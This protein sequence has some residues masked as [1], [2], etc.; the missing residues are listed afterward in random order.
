[1]TGEVAHVETDMPEAEA[2]DRIREIFE[3]AAIGKERF[4]IRSRGRRRVAILPVEEAISL[5][6]LLTPGRLPDPIRR[7]ILDLLAAHIRA[8]LDAQGV[9]DE[10][11]ERDFNEYRRRRR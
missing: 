2:A 11:I 7:Q 9:T 10:D 6:G 4:Y 5:E 1:M 3:R 8:Q